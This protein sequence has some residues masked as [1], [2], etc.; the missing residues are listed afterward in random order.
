M[1]TKDKYTSYVGHVLGSILSCNEFI[2]IVEELY[3]K[4]QNDEITVQNFKKIIDNMIV[5]LYF[6]GEYDAFGAAMDT[7]DRLLEHLKRN[8]E[9]F[10]LY[11]L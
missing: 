5:D 7:T 9:I 10:I 3:V 8:S 2:E 6:N 11:R 1:T 4:C